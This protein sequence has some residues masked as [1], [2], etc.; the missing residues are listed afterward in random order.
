M[1]SL[2]H[3]GIYAKQTD[4]K[5]LSAKH[6][7]ELI[8]TKFEEQK[9]AKSVLGVRKPKHQLTFR[10]SDRG[11]IADVLRLMII[12]ANNSPQH[13]HAERRRI[14]D[15]FEKFISIF[16]D[17]PEEVIA[18]CTRDVD[19]GTPDEEFEEAPPAELSNNRKT[20]PANGKKNNDLRRGVLD[21][22]R[23]GVRGRTQKEDSASGSKESTPDVDSAGNDEAADAE[24]QA[25]SEVT[26]ERWAATPSAAALVGSK[27]LFP[28]EQEFNAEKGFKRDWYRLY[29][30]QHIYVFFVIFHHLYDRLKIIKDNEQA[31]VNE[32]IRISQPKPAKELNLI[33]E[34][35]E[36]F[37]PIDQSG[38][39]VKDT[40]YI[41]TLQLIDDFIV[42]DLEE[43]KY[44]DFLRH[45]YLQNGWRLYSIA[46]IL[47][48]LCRLGATCS[49]V[50]SKEKTPDLL[51]QFYNNR[52]SEETTYTAEINMRKQ[53]DKY[54]KDE[55]FMLEWV[56]NSFQRLKLI[57]TRLIEPLKEADTCILGP[58][59]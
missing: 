27:S 36:Y 9:T 52:R 35:D 1:K 44:Q 7:V 19:R 45:Y 12:F 39:G 10:C 40:Y 48:N 33:P 6:I 22:N 59:R 17:L 56:G 31:A 38:K 41:R 46:D 23:N 32:G 2:D 51:E 34:K 11:V 49:S 29:G 18:E 28:G 14:A 50:D 8:K 24:D 15:F 58:E 37:Q 47:K 26:N 20:R 16:F 43:S 3:Q 21:K 53:A 42:G 57:L 55:L 54:N 30:N 5:N 25:I 4:K 13:G